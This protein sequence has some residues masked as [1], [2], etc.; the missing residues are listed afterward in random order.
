MHFTRLSTIFF[1]VVLVCAPTIALA[2][3]ALD[4]PPPVP[5][6]LLPGTR[7][8]LSEERE[9][10]VTRR[11]ELMTKLG[12]HNAKCGHV[13]KGSAAA[14]R[15]RQAQ[16]DLLQ[17]LQQYAD[18]VK[19]FAVEIEAAKQEARSKISID[20]IY[21]PTSTATAAEIRR[22]VAERQ[23]EKARQRLTQMSQT[24]SF[25]QRLQTLFDLNKDVSADVAET[26]SR[27]TV[28]EIR[29][30]AVED[31]K[32]DIQRQREL[33]TML[34]NSRR[35]LMNDPALRKALQ[36]SEAELRE[37]EKE[38][39]ARLKQ[40]LI[41]PEDSDLD[42]LFPEYGKSQV[43]VWPGPKDPNPPLPNPLQ[44]EAKRQKLIQMII[45]E[46]RENERLREIFEKDDDLIYEW[47]KQDIEKYE[48]EAPPVKP[49]PSIP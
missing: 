46:R 3:A 1:L 10:L 40:G 49:S 11:T 26:R 48:K 41:L 42:L 39:D 17:E 22:Q 16:A 27:A 8:R 5:E 24:P 43:R 18:A 14:E 12:N 7:K 38:A 15:C 44:E 36:E 20:R 23:Q 21:V 9:R 35:R 32:K 25:R 6:H 47:L 33:Q 31:F 37:V 45:W 30:Q 28:E 4:E 19:K 34:E 29:A 2:Q 13:E